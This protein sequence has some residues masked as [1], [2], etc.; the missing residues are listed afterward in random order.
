VLIGNSD[1]EKHLKRLH[2]TVPWIE[3]PLAGADHEHLVFSQRHEANTVELFFDLFFV[4]NLATFTTYH[5]ITDGD[6][7]VAYVGFFGILWSSWFQVTL[8]DVRFAR[9]SL[10][11]RVCKMI[12]F[13]VFVGLALVGSSF[14]PGKGSTGGKQASNTVS[15]LH[16][17]LSA[18][19]DQIPRI[20]EFFATLLLLAEA[21][22]R[23]NT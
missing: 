4:A 21:C 18:S 13:V 19:S 9:D 15:W 10:Y 2:K 1:K 16:W 14:N 17:M 6:Y 3:D 22:W 23:F 12:Q 5:S 8:H 11:E 7:L 20:F